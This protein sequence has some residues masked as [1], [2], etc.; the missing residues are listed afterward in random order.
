MIL[1]AEEPKPGKGASASPSEDPSRAEARNG[2]GLDA[3]WGAEAPEEAA[4]KVPEDS[5]ETPP[6]GRSAPPAAATAVAAEPVA[7]AME[8]VADAAEP[9]VVAAEPVAEAPEP[10]PVRE[11]ASGAP[12]P[13]A[14][15]PDAAAAEERAAGDRATIKVIGVGGGGGNAV[16]RMIEAGVRGVEFIA[17]NTD[18]QVL[19][20]SKAAVRIQL[21]RERTAGLGCGGD[22]E[23]GRLAARD[24]MD[25]LI[26]ALSGAD[27]VFITVGE[28]GGTGTGAAPV[29]ACVAREI[30]ALCVAVATKPLTVEGRRRRKTA[31]DGI[32][33][34]REFVD[35]LICVPN[36][37]VVAVYGDKP[38]REAFR[39]ADD[40]VRQA[41]Q[42]ISDLIQIPGEINLDFADVRTAMRAQGDAVMGIGVGSGENRVEEATKAAISSPLLEDTSIRGAT[43]IIVNVTGGESLTLNEVQRAAEVVREAVA[44][45]GAGAYGNGDLEP[46]DNILLGTALEPAMDHGEGGERIL[47][48]VVATGF[49]QRNRTGA[50]PQDFQAYAE[51]ATGTFGAARAPSLPGGD[52]RKSGEPAEVLKAATIFKTPRTAAPPE[53]AAPPPASAPAPAEELVTDAPPVLE[54]EETADDRWGDL[55]TPPYLYRRRGSAPAR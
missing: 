14:R 44:P 51:R 36:D 5:G 37:R 52:P 27:M 47:V 53:E 38:I 24:D 54:P 11:P 46:G 6:E 45:E 42:G 43:S 30:K 41:V 55:E 33:E 13:D 4:A 2:S 22:P 8:P 1:F 9:V 49:P 32:R 39:D 40:V 3:A 34:L 12:S 28:G 26:E 18:A 31:D 21:G 17:A 15:A 16:N 29:V 20:R 23:V 35:T 19:E 25:A 7:E 10:G 50:T 48:T